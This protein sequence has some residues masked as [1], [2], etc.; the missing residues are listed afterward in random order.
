MEVGSSKYTKRSFYKTVMGIYIFNPLSVLQK[1]R[2]VIK[3]P[4][5]YLDTHC[6]KIDV[7]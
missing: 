6:V 3:K 2:I 4:D 1:P 5:I 7:R